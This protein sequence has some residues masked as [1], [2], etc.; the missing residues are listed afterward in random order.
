MRPIQ[1][2]FVIG[3]LL[4]S[5]AGASAQDMIW[6]QVEPDN[7]VFVEL[8]DGR[9]V[10]ELNPRFAPKTVKQFRQLVLSR[11]YDGLSFYRVIDGFVAQGGDESDLGELSEI[12][13]LDAEFAIAWDAEMPFTSVQKPDFFAD[14]TG[15]VDAFPVA[16]ELKTDMLWLS[17]CPGMVAM[18]RNE[19]ADSSRT[20]FYIVIGQA[21]RYLD[22]N[23][24]VFARVIEGM[25]VVQNIQRG[26]PSADG[27]ISSDTARSRIRSMRLGSEL[28]EQEQM[29]ALVMDSESKPFKQMLEDRR[30]RKHKFFHNKPPKVLDVCQIPNAG[31]VTK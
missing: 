31:K 24:N 25:D 15:F 2:L 14:E 11:F 8:L 18:A 12:P 19:D 6:R 30:I 3:V 26:S 28:P 10:L 9:F 27:I 1:T 13:E 20:D 23:M 16:R 5:S 21:P 17:H 7:L 29:K 4:L 22:R